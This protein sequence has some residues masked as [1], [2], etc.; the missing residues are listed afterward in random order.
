MFLTDN[1][2]NGPIWS[3][4]VE[5]I[6]CAFVFLL[7]AIAS[8]V[9]ALLSIAAAIA[10]S[11]FHPMW[12]IMFLPMFTL[13]YLIPSIPAPVW[14]SRAL[15]VSSLALLI[16]ADL[17]LGKDGLWTRAA[18]A[19]GAFGFVGCVTQQRVKFLLSKPVQFLGAISYPFYLTGIA[20]L[21]WAAPIAA[22]IL[23]TKNLI[24]QAST[25]ALISVPFEIVVSW[26]IH[27]YVELP[28]IR[29][30]NTF[31]RWLGARLTRAP[32]EIRAP[33]EYGLISPAGY[34]Q[35]SGEP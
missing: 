29:D 8:R 32:I 20:S 9:F 3:L 18:E 35:V 15:M 5:L 23:T 30:G 28:T 19:L 22:S 34:V 1:S 33:A 6:G 2:V 27:R 17:F 12:Q 25:I 26:L 11:V 7:W 31:L 21:I 10:I 16:L 24:I 13:G 14:R 4:Q